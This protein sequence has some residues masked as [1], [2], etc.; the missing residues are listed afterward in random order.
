MPSKNQRHCCK[1]PCF[2]QCCVL[3][4]C[5]RSTDMEAAS[6]STQK[7]MCMT[8]WTHTCHYASLQL[9]QAGVHGAA[10]R[11]HLLHPAASSF[12]SCCHGMAIHPVRSYMLPR[13][14]SAWT[15]R[16]AWSSRQHA[17][18]AYSCQ[19]LYIMLPWHGNASSETM[20]ADTTLTSAWTGRSAWSS[21]QHAVLPWHS[22][23]SSS[24]HLQ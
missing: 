4:E 5:H 23:A 13:L 22:N 24:F 10:S 8:Q 18:V 11:M 21:Q 14:I 15:G 19:H 17:S 20:H 7:C 12:T 3:D 6:S 1:Q 2:Y 9:G 16:S